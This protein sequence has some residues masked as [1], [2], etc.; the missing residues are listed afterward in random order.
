MR[1]K[2]WLH[3]A[4]TTAPA[5]PTVGVA[6]GANQQNLNMALQ[7]AS[8][9]PELAKLVQSGTQRDPKALQAGALNIAQKTMAGTPAPPTAP[10]AQPVTS[11]DVANELL[12]K[13]GMAGMGQTMTPGSM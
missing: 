3:V 10:G 13:F 4:E 6:P 2:D 12:K 8:Q 7:K 9:H 11:V 5:V 1:F